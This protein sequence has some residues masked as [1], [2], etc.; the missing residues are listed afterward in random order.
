MSR[1]DLKVDAYARIDEH[2]R[3]GSTTAKRAPRLISFTTE[4]RRTTDR[5][6]KGRGRCATERSGSP[7]TSSACRSG[8]HRPWAAAGCSATAPPHTAFRRNTTAISF[9]RMMDGSSSASSRA[10]SARSSPAKAIRTAHGIRRRQRSLRPAWHST[11]TVN[12]SHT[13]DGHHRPEF[14]RL[15]AR[16]LRQARQLGTRH[17]VAARVRRRARLCGGLPR[18]PHAR[19]DRA[20]W[21]LGR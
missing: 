3:T 20:Q 16:R 6:A 21:I 7:P 8:S 12:G 10:A 1:P 19:A 4:P 2:E 5:P 13:T 14:R 18:R 17:A 15:L 11:S 9:S